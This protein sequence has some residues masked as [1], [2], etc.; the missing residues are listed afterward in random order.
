[1]PTTR[2]KNLQ[3]R[4]MIP[5]LAPRPGKDPLI[6]TEGHPVLNRNAFLRTIRRHHVLGSATLVD[7]GSAQALLLTRSLKPSHVPSPDTFFRVASITK[8]AAATVV[9]RMAE[10]GLLELDEEILP[11][12]P[13]DNG[14]ELLRGI[15]F[16]QLLSHT[17]GLLDPES[18][19]KDLNEGRPLPETLMSVRRLAHGSGFHYS[20]LGYGIL[21]CVMESVLNQS[22]ASIFD[23]WLFRPLGMRASLGGYSLPAE[24]IMPVTRVLVYREGRDVVRTPLGSRPLV[25]ADPMKHF[26]Y[27]AGSMYVDIRSLHALM[28]ML[29]LGGNGFLKEQ[30]VHEM[31]REHASYGKL[32]P[33][34]SYGLG[35]LRIRDRSLAGGD[36][37]G[38]QGFAYGCVDGAF[39]EEGTERMFLFLNG[40]CSEARS[41][42]LGLAN[43]DMA[44]W[45][46][47]KELPSWS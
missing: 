7:N 24:R 36:L 1:M 15:T 47:R 2:L 6:L 8:V 27:T 28:R 12:L 32:S 9:L 20:N 21:G 19:E 4:L 45:A 34:L 39:W 14:L 5:F 46:F 10:E 43:R 41:G 40:G 37:I 26:G 44:F 3:Y 25:S 23:E 42:R 13:A 17:S 31:C 33:T 30:S 18:L 35:L 38:H 11:R 29:L 22:V 16:R